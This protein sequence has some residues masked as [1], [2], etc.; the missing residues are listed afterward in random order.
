VPH[1]PW[2]TAHSGPPGVLIWPRRFP[3]AT[4]FTCLSEADGPVDVSFRDERSGS[5]VALALPGER[6]ALLLL[7]ADGAPLSAC[8]PGPLHVGGR[9]LWAEGA[10]VLR[11]NEG[12]GPPERLDLP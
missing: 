2:L 9:K 6:A 1:T 5:E 4:L 12:L 3:A 8:V 7:A 10:A 11:W